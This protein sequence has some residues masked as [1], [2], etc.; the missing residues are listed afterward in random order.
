M[1]SDPKGCPLFQSNIEAL[2]N[3]QS[4]TIVAYG[5]WS[6]QTMSMFV[7]WMSTQSWS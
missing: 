5:H 6:V 7:E 4:K 3:S 2:V 1:L